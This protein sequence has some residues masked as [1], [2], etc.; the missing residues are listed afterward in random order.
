MDLFPKAQTQEPGA[1]L[2]Q[3]LLGPVQYSKT[4]GSLQA[5]VTPGPAHK[6]Q[7]SSEGLGGDQ[8]CPYQ[9]R[10]D[11]LKQKRGQEI[12][13]VFPFRLSP[14]HPSSVLFSPEKGRE[15][16]CSTAG[17]SRGES[18]ATSLHA[19]FLVALPV[20][21]QCRLS[22]HHNTIICGT[23]CSMKVQG[24][25][26]KKQ[27]ESIIKGAGICS[28][29]SGRAAYAQTQVGERLAAAKLLLPIRCAVVQ[30]AWDKPWL[31]LCG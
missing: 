18:C 28:D 20:C 5:E 9:P 26:L 23:Q 29:A 13:A 25:F 17:V 19:I 21:L 16:A 3:L 14:P 8:R 24:C 2:Q 15:E 10:P 11:F 7:K 1:Q 12:S 31:T 6:L 27:G 4:R 30:P 22:S